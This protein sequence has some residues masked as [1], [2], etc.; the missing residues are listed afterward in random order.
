MKK[1]AIS[2]TGYIIDKGVV[3]EE[4]RGIYEY[5]FQIALEVILSMVIS[6][7]VANLLHMLLEGI[8][9]FI[10]F[11]PLRSYAGGFHLRQYIPCLILSCLTY[12]GVLLIV[13]FAEISMYLSA[14]ILFAL[15]IAVWLLD[16]VKDRTRQV[17]KEAIY[18]KR[19][20]R[21]I[22]S[23]D[24]LL[25]LIYLFFR[26]DRYLLLMML[27]FLLMVITMSLDKI[28]YRISAL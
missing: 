4:E 9:F 16:S 6:I 24:T 26:E 15:I 27:T 3:K 12:T 25:S 11:I 19:R 2:L 20:L 21:K 28:Q 18:F 5:G 17:N 10:V 13:K 1:L 8:L 23:I 7:L 22:L 14:L